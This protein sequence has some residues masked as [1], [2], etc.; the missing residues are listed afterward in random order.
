AI[1]WLVADGNRR[2]RFRGIARNRLWLAH[3]AAAINLKRLLALGLNH[4]GQAWI[5]PITT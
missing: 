3:R 1:A 4:N 5:I 2:V